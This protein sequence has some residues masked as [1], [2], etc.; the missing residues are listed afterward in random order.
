MVTTCLDGDQAGSIPSALL[1]KRL[2]SAIPRRK[3]YLIA[4]P[5]GGSQSHGPTFCAGRNWLKETSCGS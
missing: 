3:G 5:C 4:M 2:L 1:D